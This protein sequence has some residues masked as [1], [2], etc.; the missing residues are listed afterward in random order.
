[1]GGP[2]GS[3]LTHHSEPE[4]ARIDG[5]R[6]AMRQ[7]KRDSSYGLSK[8]K[9]IVCAGCDLPILDRFLLN[10]LDRSWHTKCVQC[11]ECKSNLQ[12]KCFSR[13]GKLYC[14][15]DFF[16][17]LTPESE[18]KLLASGIEIRLRSRLRREAAKETALM[19]DEHLLFGTKCSG[20]S[21][22]I[23]PTDLVRRAR[24]KVFHLKCFTCLVCRKQL[25]TGEELYI[26]DEN[27][28]VCKEDYMTSRHNQVLTAGSPGEPDLDDSIVSPPELDIGPHGADSD[29]EED[30]LLGMGPL[31][32]L[33]SIGRG[34]GHHSAIM[35][36]KSSPM[37]AS[38]SM[39]DSGIS[40][41]N[42]T[43]GGTD[44]TSPTHASGSNS[45][46]NDENQPGGTKRRGPRTTI[47][48]KQLETLK[49]AFAA[50]PKPTRHIREQL[51]Q[52]TGLNMR[53]IQ[54][55]IL[56]VVLGQLLCC[57]LMHYLIAIAFAQ[58]NH[59]MAEMLSR[60]YAVDVLQ[61]SQHCYTTSADASD[62]IEE[63]VLCF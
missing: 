47:K 24:S 50:T 62:G 57:Y 23:L 13:E 3:Q 58:H 56:V 30:N 19:T 54:P 36:S 12:E 15:N 6:V 43:N 35:S 8:M 53:V 33:S 16:K 46:G 28:F 41:P 44:P 63:S 10:V 21:Q 14:R 22:G 27:R 2:T 11:A 31:P 17:S 29:H 18:S 42:G 60:I 9:M 25:S 4:S 61:E 26:L 48:A 5:K 34:S 49:A 20:C 45:A 38:S 59:S 32:S 39:S 7:N 52:E 1:M 51:A 37:S 55:C 40:G